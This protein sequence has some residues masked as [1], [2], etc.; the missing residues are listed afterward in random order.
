[1]ETPCLQR[2]SEEGVTLQAERVD[3]LLP[4]VKTS[5]SDDVIV[6]EAASLPLLQN[7][8]PVTGSNSKQNKP[9]Q[10]QLQPIVS[11]YAYSSSDDEESDSLADSLSPNLINEAI[12][13][14]QTAQAIPAAQSHRLANRTAVAR[15]NVTAPSQQ[16][17]VG[18]KT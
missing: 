6:S 18:K 3:R 13:R 12:G 14:F 17:F 7:L 10:P 11:A 9:P 16:P 2:S 4:G 8:V 5:S 15:R 1:M